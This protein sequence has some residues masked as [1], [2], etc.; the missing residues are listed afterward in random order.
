[1]ARGMMNGSRRLSPLLIGMA[2]S[3]CAGAP[4][5]VETAT[6]APALVGME[7]AV[8]VAE[9]AILPADLERRIGYLASDRLKG[10]A[11]GS[12]GLDSAA[13]YL[14]REFEAL[15]L[16]PAGEKG[17]IHEW[18]YTTIRVQQVPNVVAKIPGTDPARAGEYIIY[19]AHMDH[20]GVGQ[21]TFTGDSI[22]N[23]ADDNASGSAALLSIAEAFM[24]LPERP[25]RPILFVAVSGEEQGLV[26]SRRF[27]GDPS[28]PLD[29]AVA[30]LNMDMISRNAPDSVFVIGYLFSTLGPTMERIARQNPGLGLNVV[31]DP[32]PEQRFFLRS[33]HFHFARIGIPAV[34]VSTLLHED[35]HRPTDEPA[36]TDP[37][38]AARVAR[39]LFLTGFDIANRAGRPSWTPEGRELL[40]LT[41]PGG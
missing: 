18:P 23:G 4:A 14:A 39:L 37:D 9:R 40:G 29:S 38:K 27:V 10:R 1:M 17:F 30:N 19:S 32:Q 8:R 28:V 5:A 41:E 11:T 35:Y 21:P 22:Y 2:L 3:A 16:E 34:A 36:R 20:L 24:A 7:E 15:G 33:D 13:A 12:P 25:E 31:P 6:R 26:G